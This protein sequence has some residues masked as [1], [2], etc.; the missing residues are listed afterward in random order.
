M[1]LISQLTAKQRMKRSCQ[2]DSLTPGKYRVVETAGPAGYDTS[3][4]NYEFQ[5]DNM[6]NH[7]HGK[8]T[9]MTN[10]VW[11]LTHQID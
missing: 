4:G 10:N 3:P 1:V 2:F 7:L 11:T 6:E 9:E 8:N 5:I